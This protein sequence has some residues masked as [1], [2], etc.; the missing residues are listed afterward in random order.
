MAPWDDGSL[1]TRFLAPWYPGSH[2]ALDK[3][4]FRIFFFS[5]FLLFLHLDDHMG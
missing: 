4:R 2:C 3:A 1:E 5:F